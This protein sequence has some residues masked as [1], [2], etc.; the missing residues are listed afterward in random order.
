MRAPGRWT[1]GATGWSRAPLPWTRTLCGFHGSPTGSPWG[2]G[3]K[4]AKSPVA[5]ILGAVV[6]AADGSS[7]TSTATPTETSSAGARLR[8][9]GARSLLVPPKP[10]NDGWRCSLLEVPRGGDDRRVPGPR[11]NYVPVILR[12]DR[13]NP[14]SLCFLR[15]PQSTDAQEG[16]SDDH[17]REPPRRGPH[18]GRAWRLLHQDGTHEARR[19]VLREG[20]GALRASGARRVRARGEDPQQVTASVPTPPP[21]SSRLMPESRS[22]RWRNRS[23]CLP[24]SGREAGGSRSCPSSPGRRTSRADVAG[25]ERVV[26]PHGYGGI[27]RRSDDGPRQV[28]DREDRTIPETPAPTLTGTTRWRF[29]T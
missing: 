14:P 29:E 12:Q 3:S 27:R 20:Q 24:R 23:P 5:W 22:S 13:C 21:R 9:V 15:V 1:T 2:R 16:I 10:H 8:A 7:T 6:A 18:D 19:N 26:E 11:R 17:L 28:L 25:T 4:L